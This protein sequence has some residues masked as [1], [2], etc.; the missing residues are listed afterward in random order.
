MEKPATNG[1]TNTEHLGLVPAKF[2]PAKPGEKRKFPL[3]FK[4]A[5][6]DRVQHGETV[7]DVCRTTGVH[8]SQLH[9]WL[10]GESLSP[11]GGGGSGRQARSQGSGRQA[12]KRNEGRA[13]NKKPAPTV[14]AINNPEISQRLKDAMYFLDNAEKWMYGAIR[15]GELTKFDQA[16]DWTR[17]ALTELRKLQK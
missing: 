5:C 8:N 9:R 10:K 14:R 4:K 7:A 16:H 12:R 3:E 17:A 2:K 13:V 6:V 15:S 11:M 1:I